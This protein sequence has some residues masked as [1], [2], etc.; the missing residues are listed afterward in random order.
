M[1][2]VCPGSAS[3]F[4]LLWARLAS[5]QDEREQQIRAQLA[6]LE[7][8]L[9]NLSRNLLAGVLSSTLAKMLS[10]REEE[11][12]ALLG[13]LGGGQTADVKILPHPALL[14]HFEQRVTKIREALNDPA[15]KSEAAETIRSLIDRVTISTEDGEIV[16]DIEASTTSLLDFAQTR[17]APAAFAMEAVL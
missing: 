1:T 8:E 9:E 17:K 15:H 5:T 2:T 10:D 16:A 7:I 14:R 13:R 6:E 11:R 4:P 12:E 3:G